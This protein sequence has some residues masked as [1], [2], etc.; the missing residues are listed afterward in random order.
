MDFSVI[1]AGLAFSNNHH[2]EYVSPAVMYFGYARL[3]TEGSSL[4]HGTLKPTAN[5]DSEA[6]TNPAIEAQHKQD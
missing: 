4:V 1:I 6:K 2:N 5:I 3:V